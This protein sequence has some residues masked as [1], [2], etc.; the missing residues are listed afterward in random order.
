MTRLNSKGHGFGGRG[1]GSVCRKYRVR[2][3][4][5]H[6]GTGSAENKARSPTDTVPAV[7]H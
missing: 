1:R 7:P 2:C 5:D 6:V 3:C 4:S